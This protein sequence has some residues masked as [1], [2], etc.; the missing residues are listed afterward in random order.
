[1]S[2]AHLIAGAERTGDGLSLSVPEGWRQGRTAFGG[3]SAAVAYEAAKIIAPSP[4][5]LRS[6]QVAFIGPVSET[7]TAS[8][9]ILRQG[10][11]SLFVEASVHC[12]GK[13]ALLTVFAFMA[14]RP[15]AVER[16]APPPPKVPAPE[17]TLLWDRSRGPEFAVQFEARYAEDRS[18]RGRGGFLRWMRL[19][20]REGVDAASELLL[21]ADALPPAAMDLM[22]TPAP[23][24]SVTWMVNFLTGTPRTR[25]GWWLLD[26]TADEA[27]GGL[28]SQS[29]RM[30]S[31]SGEA[32]GL[33]MQSAALFG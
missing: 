20:D 27:R 23:V 31:A 24:S 16:D 15:S 19:K 6:A 28:S 4:P 5:P 10:K 33:G 13:L 7:L 1:V 26:S 17:D 12:E 3:F 30:W 32:V 11:S 29:M 21:V 25:D 2:F 8:A 18:Q 22:Q 14:D 9:R